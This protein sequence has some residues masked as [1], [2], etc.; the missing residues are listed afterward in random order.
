MS[1]SYNQWLETAYQI[2]AKKGPDSLTIKG[3]SETCELPRTNFYYYFDNKEDL[4][5]KLIRLHFETTTQL[6]NE[7]LRKRLHSYIPDLYIILYDFKL[8]LQF[9]YQLFKN[10][11]ILKY[12]KAYKKGVALSNELILPKFKSFFKLDLPDETILAL[13]ATVV[14][15]WY[16]RVNIDELSVDNMISLC[17]EIMDSILPLVEKGGNL[18]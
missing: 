9:S 18:K 2:F 13:W 11:D 15:T 1:K 4:I 10:R 6:F 14:D 16:S 8:G 5:D 17:Y 3:L 12:N 7:A